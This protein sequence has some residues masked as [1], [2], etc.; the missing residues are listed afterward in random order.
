MAF[1]TNYG[2]LIATRFLLGL[3]EAACLPLFAVITAQW[4]RRADQPLK[5]AIWYSM[6]GTSNIV[7]AFMS[8]GLGQIK[9]GPLFSWQYIFMIGGIITIFSPILIWWKLDNHISTARFLSEE[10]KLKGLEMLKS[11]Q[12]GVGSQDFQWKQMWEAMLEP[13]MYI[14][15]GMSLTLN[16]GASV[17]NVFGPLILAGLPIQQSTVPLMNTVFGAL[18]FIAII[19]ASYAAYQWKLKGPVLLALVVPVIVGIAL[20]WAIPRTDSNLGPLL[21]GY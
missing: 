9:S 18:Q 4:F 20:L 14:W 19:G 2:S 16:V 5:V 21:L 10:D 13:K 17:T 8:Y 15:I 11:N 6:N 7:A 12:T 3:F 1:S